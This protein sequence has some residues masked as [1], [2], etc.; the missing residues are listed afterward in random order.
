MRVASVVLFLF[1]A[2]LARAQTISPGNTIAGLPNS[3][4]QKTAANSTSVTIAS[5]QPAIPI[6]G[7]IAVT[8]TS[9]SVGVNGSTAPTSSTQVG[10]QD[11]SG[12]LQAI[13][14]TANGITTS[15]SQ[16]GA[17][18]VGQSGSWNVG[19]SGTWTVGRSWTLQPSVDAVGV[20][21]TV[22]ANAGGKSP[23]DLLRL[24]YAVTNVATSAFTQVSA[25]LAGACTAVD[26]FDSS[27]Q[28]LQLGVN[29]VAKLYVTPGGNGPVPLSLSAGS[30]ISLK[31]V[32]SAATTGEF[33]LNCYQ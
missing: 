21:G 19:Q 23:V 17:W 14:I 25:S 33:D 32:S 7:T 9:A 2:A 27:G 18:N 28:T 31:A 5:D 6:T 11:G 4:G 30:V 22:T 20:T 29:G 12:N 16:A 3:T 24:N 26:I 13:S 15:A 8:A 1:A 10:A